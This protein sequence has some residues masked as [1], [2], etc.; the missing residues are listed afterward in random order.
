MC[1]VFGDKQRCWR[2]EKIKFRSKLEQFIR[3]LLYSIIKHNFHYII[4]IIKFSHGGFSKIKPIVKY[5][6]NKIEIEL[7]NK[8]QGDSLSIDHRQSEINRKKKA[9]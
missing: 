9:L 5:R 4:Y 7:W 3:M 1:I 2:V 8:K 6:R